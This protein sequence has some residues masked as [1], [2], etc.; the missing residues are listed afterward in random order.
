MKSLQCIA[1]STAVA[2][3][4]GPLLLFEGEDV[5]VSPKFSVL[6]IQ[7]REKNAAKPTVAAPRRARPRPRSLRAPLPRS[8]ARRGTPPPYFKE[9]RGLFLEKQSLKTYG[10]SRASRVSKSPKGGPT[11]ARRVRT[12]SRDLA[13]DTSFRVFHPPTLHKVP[14]RGGSHARKGLDFFETLRPPRERALGRVVE[15]L[16]PTEIYV[17]VLCVPHSSQSRP[18][19]VFE[20]HHSLSP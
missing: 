16:R 13:R 2:H 1:L 8:G 4:R 19:V 18:C 12:I 5:Y 9:G 10:V 3:T 14:I 7:M 20:C 15:G 6:N 17:R 11:R